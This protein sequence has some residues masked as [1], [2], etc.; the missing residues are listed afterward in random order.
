VVEPSNVTQP[1]NVT[2]LSSVRQQSEG[3]EWPRVESSSNS[4]A[5]LRW[6]REAAGVCFPLNALAGRR[7]WGR[8]TRQAHWYREQL[9]R[10]RAQRAAAPATTMV[11]W[12]P[13]SPLPL[14]P[15]L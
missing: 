14:S 15:V 8:L 10:A 4:R 7:V 12:R 5:A 13:E 3:P 6:R 1:P 11:R 2:Q 9:C